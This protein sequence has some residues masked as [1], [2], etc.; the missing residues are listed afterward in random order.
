MRNWMKKG[1]SLL[2]A[3]TL[4]MGLSATAL[5]ADSSV[6][7]ENGKL[8]AF[9][10][11]SVYTDSDL[12]DN[13]KGVMPGDTL[14]EKVAIE[15]RS[16][17]C[18]YIKVYM[19]AVL[20]DEKGNPVSEKVLE[21][22]RSD[23]RREGASEVEYMHDFLSQLSLNVKNGDQVIYSASPDE[24]DGL[25]QNVYLGTL[26][27]GESAKLDVQLSVPMEM[28]N[29]Y[30]DRIGEVDWVFVV[31]GFDDPVN[32]PD[33]GSEET[34]HENGGNNGN[35]GAGGLGNL[36]QTGQLNWPIPV[37]G[38]LG[39]ALIAYGVYVTNKKRRNEDA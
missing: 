33:G 34:G 12:F 27:Q 10:P 8:I 6:T 36:I 15:N 17:D 37:M 2:L 18:D 39:V 23:E 24:L 22:L 19:R 14:G 29:E 35:N 20:H 32:P 25:S 11:G 21:E 4:M 3:L 7:F 13:F 30:A 38:A 31:E 16:K 1:I 5:A 26:R 9:E 28:G